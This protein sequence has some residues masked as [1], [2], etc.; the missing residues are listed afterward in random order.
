MN[1]STLFHVSAA[2]L[3]VGL[4]CASAHAAVPAAPSKLAPSFYR[5]TAGDTA[6]E[7]ACTAK[8]GVVSTDQDGYRIC[9]LA[10]ACPAPGSAART[11]KLDTNDAAAERKCK[12]ACGVVSM[13]ASGAKVCT[14]P[15]AG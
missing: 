6:A 11:T 4:F 7:Q 10:R 9:T 13:D 12:D 8:G 15:D 3:A 14:K 1:V 2:A 5:L